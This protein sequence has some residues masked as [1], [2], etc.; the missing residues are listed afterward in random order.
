MLILFVSSLETK[1]PPSRFPIRYPP[2]SHLSSLPPHTLLA[3]N[4]SKDARIAARR[5]S[6]TSVTQSPSHATGCAPT[7]AHARRELVR[8]WL[9]PYLCTCTV[10]I[11]SCILHNS[12]SSLRTNFSRVLYKH[13]INLKQTNGHRSSPPPSQLKQTQRSSFTSTLTSTA[14]DRTPHATRTA[15][16]PTWL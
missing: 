7:F 14:R 6:L 10:C 16:G 2:C 15:R 13:I 12:G 9:F 5:H 11:L 8:I 3:S 1:D 4:R